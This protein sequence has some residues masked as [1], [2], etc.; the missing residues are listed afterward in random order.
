[1]LET[2]LRQFAVRPRVRQQLS[3]DPAMSPVSSGSKKAAASPAT[4]GMEETE[5]Q[6]TGAPQAIA[7]ST[8]NPNPS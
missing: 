7:S 5:E 6:A 8:G 2:R 1:M 4:S 3:V